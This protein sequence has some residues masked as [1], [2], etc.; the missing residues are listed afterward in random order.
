MVRAEIESGI[1]SGLGDD[2]F[3]IGPAKMFIDGSS[4]GPTCKMRE[5]YASNPE[6]SGILYMN[7]DSLS[8][9]GDAHR[10]GWQITAHAMGDQAV[11]MMV[12]TIEEALSGQSR[13][14]HRHRLEHSGFTPEDLLQKVQS[15]RSIPIPNP[16]FLYEFGD[17][18]LRDYGNRVKDMFPMRTLQSIKSLLPSVQTARLQ[19]QTRSP[20]SIQLSVVSVKAALPLER[21][22]ASL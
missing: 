7:Q 9:L 12:Q 5:P 3:K 16:A 10:H 2:N 8:D 6:D 21:R 4:S 19:R 15:T 22:N 17:G 1:S 20:A 18:Y 11:E 14:D 13:E